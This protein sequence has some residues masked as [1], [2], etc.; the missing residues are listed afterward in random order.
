MGYPLEVWQIENESI[1]G[2]HL[3]REEIA[4]VRIGPN[5]IVAVRRADT[6]G[7]MLG[8][9]SWV[10]VTQTGQLSAGVRYLPGTVQAISINATGV[11]LST[12]DKSVA[13]LLLPAMP[14]L[15]TPASLIIPRDWLRPDRVVEIVQA[16]KQTL[17]VK[18]GFSVEK[19]LDYERVSFSLT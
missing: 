19:G 9:I 8:A 6:D 15:K 17:T 1:L 11:N 3:L 16:D 12:S 2:A 10:H 5:Q 18:L 7:F 4:G 13:A 14:A